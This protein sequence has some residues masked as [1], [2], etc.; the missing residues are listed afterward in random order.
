MFSMHFEFA[1]RQ[2]MDLDYV[3]RALAA[4]PLSSVAIRESHGYLVETTDYDP[5]TGREVKHSFR[6]GFDT[7][8]LVCETGD[9]QQYIWQ[10]STCVME[11]GITENN[12]DFQLF[13]RREHPS[14]TIRTVMRYSFGDPEACVVLHYGSP[15][16]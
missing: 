5:E 2:S 12:Q 13:W 8:D 11:T 7:L 3:N 16:R 6:Y 14:Q 1:D 10:I 4:M 15:I 9:S